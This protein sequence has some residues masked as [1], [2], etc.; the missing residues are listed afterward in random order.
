MLGRHTLKAH[1]QKQKVIA[2]SS[3]EAELHAAA[4]GASE[5]NGGPEHDV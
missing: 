4:S 3:A 2:K 5:A 1:T